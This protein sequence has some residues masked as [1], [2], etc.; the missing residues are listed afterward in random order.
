MQSPSLED[1]PLASWD[2]V[3]TGELGNAI[4][5]VVMANKTP[6]NRVYAN[7]IVE[8]GSV[9]EQD[10][11]QGLAHFLEHMVFQGTEQFP[12]S[13]MLRD[14]LASW[15]MSFGG[16]ANAS[17]DYRQ[18]CY[19]LE[20]PTAS[21]AGAQTDTEGEDTKLGKEDCMEDDQD[22]DD[23]EDQDQEDGDQED[24]LE[25]EDNDEEDGE[26][27]ENGHVDDHEKG[28][29]G[30][31]ESTLYRVLNVL[32]QLLFRALIQQESVDLERGAVLGELTED[33]SVEYRTNVANIQ[34]VHRHN[35][36]SRRFPIGLKSCIEAAQ[37]PDLKHFYNTHYRPNNVVIFVVGDI[38][39]QQCI[40]IIE[41]IF[42]S[43]SIDPIGPPPPP[44]D[45]SFAVTSPIKLL[46]EDL[47]RQID[48]DPEGG[49]SMVEFIDLNE[50]NY[51]EFRHELITTVDVDFILLYPLSE[52]CTRVSH[53]RSF[54]IDSIIEQ[55]F[56]DRIFALKS[57]FSDS[58]FVRFASFFPLL[59]P[60]LFSCC[61]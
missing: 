9:N 53:F 1:G 20:A 28:E 26:G 33:N 44:I 40:S 13:Q 4:R 54:I 29:K 30:E 36:L 21:T 10:N 61:V 12:S 41:K 35:I 8:I 56:D 46:A 27:K 15:G 59:S 2:R 45:H 57:L 11:E 22:D 14:L 52:P 49:I 32:H 16:D 17:T 31:E 42:S 3:L 58:P 19:T 55:S 37:P 48:L 34:F 47:E 38:D 60:S 7:A 24:D 50:G 43:E 5:Y 51:C 6:P 23:Q 18:T 25:E 39:P